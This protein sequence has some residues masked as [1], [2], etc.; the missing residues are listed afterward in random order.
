MNSNNKGQS[1]TKSSSHDQDKNALEKNQSLNQQDQKAG[2]I[3]PGQQAN[4][5]RD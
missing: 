4:L 3:N 2:H 5:Q 1:N